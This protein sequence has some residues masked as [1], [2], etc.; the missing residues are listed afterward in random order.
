M[1]QQLQELESLDG[2]LADLQ[3]AKNG[4]TGDQMNQ[5]GEGIN[6]YGD[7]MGNRRNGQNGLGR[8]R[9]R[10]DRPEAPDSTATY[11]TKVA[12]QYRKG[13]AV[14][15]GTSPFNQ[16]MKGQSVIDVQGEVDASAGLSA[17][18]LTNQ[19]IPKNV[20]KHIRG[21]FDQINKGR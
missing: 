18:A 14:V 17:E 19:K 12:Q 7:G 15:E 3:D 4:M 16:P 6:Q 21:Y 8:G 13:K 9:G 5:L 2:A 10:G 20:E 1:A 11:N